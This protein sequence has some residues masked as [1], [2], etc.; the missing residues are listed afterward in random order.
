MINCCKIDVIDRMFIKLVK[1]QVSPTDCRPVLHSEVCPHRVVLTT[2]TSGK[3]VM[4]LVDVST[5][6]SYSFT[7]ANTPRLKYTHHHP[8]CHIT[9]TTWS[10]QRHHFNVGHIARLIQHNLDNTRPQ[11]HKANLMPLISQH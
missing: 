11:Q 7:L 1:L 8:P 10:S 2:V 5:S 4:I 6:L 9:C 3:F